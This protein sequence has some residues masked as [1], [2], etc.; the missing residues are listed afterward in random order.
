MSAAV[1]PVAGSLRGVE[2]QA[3]ELPPAELPEAV[4]VMRSTAGLHQGEVLF[5]DERDG[6]FIGP[7]W[8]GVRAEDVRRGWGWYF[9]RAQA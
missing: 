7:A 4:R 2:F 5:L 6:V 1:F 9:G 8:V 3:L